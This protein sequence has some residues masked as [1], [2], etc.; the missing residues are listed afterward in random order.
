M[1]SGATGI[2]MFLMVIAADDGVMPQ[3]VEHARILE[4]LG[5][6]HGVI[7]ISKMDIIDPQPAMQEASRLLPGCEMIGCSAQ[8][9]AGL[10]EL[11]EAIQR[12]AEQVPSRARIDS[13]VALHIDRVFTIVGRG[14]V[15]TGTLWSGRIREGDTLTLAP[16]QRAVRVRGLQIHSLQQTEVQAGQRVAVNLT[17]VSLDQV[18]PGDVLGSPGSLEPTRILDC[19]LDLQ[20]AAHNMPIIAH[21]GTRQAPGRL[22]HLGDELWQLRLERPLLALNGNRIVIRRTSP[23][24]TLGGG[25]ILDAKAK[26]HGPKPEI[27]EELLQLRSPMRETASVE[28]AE[29]SAP[30]QLRELPP[31]DKLAQ[32]LI[33]TYNP[34]GAPTQMEASLAARA[35]LQQRREELQSAQ[36][37]V[38]VAGRRSSGD[39]RKE[40]VNDAGDLLRSARRWLSPSMKRVLNGTGVVLHTNLGR[41]PLA[42]SAAEA[43]NALARG[44]TN[45]ELD[46]QTGQRSS[47][48]QHL[49]D[50]VCELTG[51]E[52]A[53]AVNNSAAGVLLAV[54][55]VAGPDKTIVV[56]RGHLVEIGGGFR[57]PEIIAHAGASMIEIGT[58]NRTL[59]E[60]YEQALQN[61]GEVILRVH[62]SNFKTLGYTSEVAIEQLCKLGVPVIDDV[63]SGALA[64]NLPLLA[65]EPSIRRSVAAGADVVCFSGDKLLGGPQAGI[66]AGSTEAIQACRRHPIARALRIGRLP[67]GALEATLRLYRDPERA[68]KEIPT[69]AML[70]IDPI[71]LEHRAKTL[72]QKIN[73]TLIQTATK[74]GGGALPLLELQT[75]AVALPYHGNPIRLATALRNAD[76]PLLA[77][78]SDGQVIVD[79]RTLPDNHLTTA[80]NVI[81]H[82]IAELLGTSSQSIQSKIEASSPS[83]LEE[84]ADTPVAGASP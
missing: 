45:L 51:A 12:L 56:S 54:T 43:V 65:E 50:L 46:L 7:A 14:T 2:D 8:T 52:D 67:L 33:D 44:Y 70:S 29:R 28:P 71:R 82:V 64:E 55:A 27:L 79:P 5:I 16:E 3:T 19:R 31:V 76:P 4:V 57:M 80:T 36:A 39:E 38:G 81:R 84:P 10:E 48:N 26:R 17:G 63:G 20:N 78:I 61:G 75:P 62:P 68:L 59:V 25:T 41:A 21:H 32:Q 49:T 66:L 47:R 1:V 69:L 34:G 35:A 74:I 18:H 9:G 72:A 24:E 13:G 42:N 30:E 22:T 11:R 77:R 83:I 60:D 23:P 73:G 53:I 6:E 40:N 58:T 37:A 15:V